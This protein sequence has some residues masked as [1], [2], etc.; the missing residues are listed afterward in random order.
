MTDPS[1][2]F[3][4][5]FAC[6]TCHGLSLWIDPGPG[7]QWLMDLNIR[8]TLLIVYVSG[9]HA[10]RYHQRWAVVICSKTGWVGF[11]DVYKLQKIN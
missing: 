1:T 10:G 5:A 9:T 7:G 4:G 8:D 11:V 2:L 3:P 6:A